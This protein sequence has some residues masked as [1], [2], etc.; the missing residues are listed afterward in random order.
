MVPLLSSLISLRCPSTS[1]PIFSFFH[2]PL[3][4]HV[5]S[6]L[7]FLFF[8][9]AVPGRQLQEPARREQQQAGRQAT[10]EQCAEP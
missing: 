10:R 9:R 1:F 5:P 7:D 4:S 2:L 8:G 3:S 6:P